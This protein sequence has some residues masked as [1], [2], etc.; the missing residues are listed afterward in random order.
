MMPTYNGSLEQAVSHALFSFY[1]MMTTQRVDEFVG[2]DRTYL[3]YLFEQATGL[4]LLECI[5]QLEEKV[6]VLRQCNGRVST[7]SGA[8]FVSP[9]YNPTVECRDQPPASHRELTFGT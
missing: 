8:Q 2:N 9:A 1:P 4:P 3:R 7:S 6:Q 5:R